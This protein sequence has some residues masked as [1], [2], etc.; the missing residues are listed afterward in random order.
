TSPLLSYSMFNLV[1]S[2]TICNGTNK[3]T[4]NFH[5]DY[6]QNPHAGGFLKNLSFEPVTG[7][8]NATIM[9]ITPKIIP[10]FG[11]KIY[12]KMIGNEKEIFQSSKEGNINVFKILTKYNRKHV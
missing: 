5:D 12:K 3:G 10:P 6:H 1:P 9:E 7:K 2:D 4:N 11:D 8:I